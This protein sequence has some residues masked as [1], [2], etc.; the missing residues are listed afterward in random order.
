MGLVFT[1]IQPLAKALSKY[2]LRTSSSLAKRL[3][4]GLYR[5]SYLSS[6]LI[7]QLPQQYQGSFPTS[8]EE[9]ILLT[10]FN[11]RR[12]TSKLPSSYLLGITLEVNRVKTLDSIQRD[13]IKPLGV[14]S[15]R[16]KLSSFYCYAFALQLI[17]SQAFFNPG[18]P[19]VIVGDILAI[20]QQIRVTSLS[21]PQLS[22]ILSSTLQALQ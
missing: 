5:A 14:Y 13:S 3:Q 22:F 21:L 12:R 8:L 2:S 19:R 9:K 1:L 11:Y 4:S 10:S 18:I 16:D 6:R 20:L 15:S 7:L 17:R